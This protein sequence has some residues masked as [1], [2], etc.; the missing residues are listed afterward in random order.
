MPK[1]WD[2]YARG[3]VAG[4]KNEPHSLILDALRARYPATSE[5]VYSNRDLAYKQECIANMRDNSADW[6]GQPEFEARYGGSSEEWESLAKAISQE[7]LGVPYIRLPIIN[8]LLAVDYGF[9]L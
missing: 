5:L 6:V 4:L 7:I 9:A 3:I 2:R 1:K 8:R